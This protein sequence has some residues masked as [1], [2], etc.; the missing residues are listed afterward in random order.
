M[1][2]FFCSLVVFLTLLSNS[3]V[4]QEDLKKVAQTGLQFLSVDHLARP[5]AMGGAF[6]LVGTGAESMFYNPSG[7]AEIGSNLEFVGSQ[8]SWIADIGYL[9][10]GLARDFGTLGVIGV[11]VIAV[12]YGE[13]VGSKVANNADGYELTD[14]GSSGGLAA[15]VTYARAVTDRFRI[16]GQV[17]LASQQLGSSTLNDGT[18]IN[19]QV[20][21]V[22]F[23]FGTT[24]YPMWKGLKLGMSIRN[25]SQQF[26]YEQVAFELPLTF[27][28]GASINVLDLLGSSS[29]D[30]SLL[31]A[32]DAVH[33]REYTERV[34]M[35]AEYL[36]RD[37]FALRAGYKTNYDEE[38]LSFGFGV[39][40][41]VVRV[42]YSYSQMNIFDGVSRITLRLA[43]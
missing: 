19:N 13:V 16:G 43:L 42:D 37:M 38:S 20:S 30:N 22:A 6:S 26:K 24:F 8:T 32:V 18:T 25:F 9:A 21:G 3:A 34:H 15:G 7:L 2:K 36:F 27:R 1:K 39:N 40:V 12:D 5:S 28:I 29:S 23:D 11:S 14:I 41:S 35:G 33:P 4:G 10:A 17:K 31:V